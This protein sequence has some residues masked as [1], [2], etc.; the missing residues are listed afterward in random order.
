VGDDKSWQRRGFSFSVHSQREASLV[1]GSRLGVLHQLHRVPTVL[2]KA[3]VG[4]EMWWRG[5]MVVGSEARVSM[6]KN[7]KLIDGL[8]YIWGFLQSDRAHQ[9]YDLYSISNRCLNHILVWIRRGLCE[10]Y[11]LGKSSCCF[12]FQW[13]R[14]REK[15]YRRV[16]LSLATTRS[17]N[18]GLALA[19]PRA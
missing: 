12:R 14:Q 19:G 4:V 2:D 16:P 9:G 18:P 3:S 11:E 13:G 5:A 6:M 15:I 1:A 8:N 7:S 17:V 10:E